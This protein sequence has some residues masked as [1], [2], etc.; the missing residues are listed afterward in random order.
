MSFMLSSHCAAFLVRPVSTWFAIILVPSRVLA[1]AWASAAS[2]AM[3]F[4]DLSDDR[5]LTMSCCAATGFTLK[6]LHYY[7]NNQGVAVT[8]YREVVFA[9][10]ADSNLV[11]GA[12]AIVD[13]AE[14][15]LA[16][17]ESGGF[18]SERFEYFF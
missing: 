7:F 14:Q 13:C 6:Q 12:V 2:I 8:I 5:I 9:F 16:E 10:T 3:V 1:S 18:T 4:S 15:D 11:D 17:S